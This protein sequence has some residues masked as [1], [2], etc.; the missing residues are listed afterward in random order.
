MNP[1]LAKG[2]PWYLREHPYEIAKADTIGGTEP[3]M[4]R[5]SAYKIKKRKKQ[6]FKTTNFKHY[7]DGFHLP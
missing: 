2:I 1:R 7:T 4:C 6:T 3:D 5:P